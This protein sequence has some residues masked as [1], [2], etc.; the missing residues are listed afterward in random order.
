M[1][2]TFYAKYPGKCPDCGEAIEQGAEVMYSADNKVVH[3]KCGDDAQA[4]A[5]IRQ[6]PAICAVCHLQTPCEHTEHLTRIGAT[7]PEQD[8][9]A[10][11]WG[12]VLTMAAETTSAAASAARLAKMVSGRPAPTPVPTGQAAIEAFFEQHPVS[13]TTLEEQ[14]EAKVPRD[15]HD[16]P[17]IQQPDGTVEPYNRASSYGGQL[18]DKTKLYDWVSRQVVRGTAILMRQQPTFLD[19]VPER[20]FDPW[21]D[22]EGKERDGLDSMANQA[23][24]AA[25]SSLKSQL[26]T[27]IH[28][29]TELIDAGDDLE[30][31]LSIFE[32]WRKDL[33]I[34]RANAYYR[35]TRELGLKWD[36]IETF[37]VQDDLQVAGT[38]DRR[39]YVPWWPEHKQTI[40]DVK[41]S[42]S[43]DFGGLQFG[44][45]LAAYAH[46]CQYVIETGERI[47]HDD[48]N[49]DWA[50]IIHV[51]RNKGGPVEAFKV[52][53]AWGWKKS[54]L[55]REVIQARREGGWKGDRAPIQRLDERELLILSCTTQ[56]ELAQHA[57]LAKTWPTWLKELAKQRW[58][59]LP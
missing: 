35:L 34:E 2:R 1:A 19:S 14:V 58:D 21:N 33:L 5:A 3:A 37:G 28:Y 50:L 9:Q 23:K 29:A 41:T 22:Q 31:K 36:T 38:W 15:R 56:A 48:M 6:V 42:G 54:R 57:E 20:L 4:V 39:G 25:G 52:N 53:I 40:G 55:A 43:M 26:G 18:D 12:E 30:N 32:P 8:R 45:Q 11:G 59:E 13:Y 47:P 51:D 44:V 49:E 17:L 24:E 16:R 46:M 10:A 27:D 7:G